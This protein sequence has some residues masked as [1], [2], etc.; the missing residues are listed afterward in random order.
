[1]A[2]EG[3]TDA[4]KFPGSKSGPNPYSGSV[5]ALQLSDCNA[6]LKVLQS[7]LVKFVTLSECGDVMDSLMQTAQRYESIERRTVEKGASPSTKDAVVTIDEK[8]DDSVTFYVLDTMTRVMQAVLNIDNSRRQ[9]ELLPIEVPAV[10][11]TLSSTQP[12]V[13]FA[14]HYL[15]HSYASATRYGAAHL[16]GVMSHVFLAQ[17]AELF[18]EKYAAA[19][20]DEQKREFASYQQAVGYLHFGVG[21][22]KTQLATNTYLFELCKKMK[23]V[24]RGVLRQEICSSLNSIYSGI[25]AS[26]DPKRAV[27]WDRFQQSGGQQ[28][29]AFNTN[30]RDV[31]ERVAKWSSKDKHALFCWELLLR[32]LVLTK[33]QD[34]FLDKKRFDVFAAVLKGLSKKDMRQQCLVLMRNYVRDVSFVFLQADI[35]T[36]SNQART[37]MQTLF[38]KKG[39][40]ERRQPGSR[41]SPLLCGLLTAS[42]PLCPL[43]QLPS[44]RTTRSR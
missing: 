5:S 18:T 10:S 26:S 42:V 15:H 37:L 6:S 30:Y 4:S 20:K 21:E 12:V 27:E 14:F 9:Q 36:W 23:D 44:L 16:L 7:W 11:G 35:A 13:D 29:D 32:M 1:M 24:D 8:Y 38:G 33:N 43:P 3:H 41:A 22:H 34:F 25:L 31:Y 28:L 39:Q 40:T 2:L 19:K 17:T